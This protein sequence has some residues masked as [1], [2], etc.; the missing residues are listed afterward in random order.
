MK[1][2]RRTD[3]QLSEMEALEILKKG[4]YGILSTVDSDGQPYGV[5][6]SYVAKDD[7]IYYHSTNAGGSK[8]D[9]IIS[10]EKVSFTAVGETKVLP[11]KFGTLYESVIVI[12]EAKLVEDE[13]ERLYAFRELLK[14]YCADFLVE[15]EKYIESAGPKAMVVKISISSLT[16]KGRR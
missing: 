5:P 15:G 1:E 2:M 13:D 8:H 11:D 7:C 10:N 12:G 9:N 16:G 14:K 4:E 3:R 6:L